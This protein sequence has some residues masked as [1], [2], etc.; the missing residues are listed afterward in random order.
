MCMVA[1]VTQA[2]ER[3]LGEQVEEIARRHGVIKR[4]RKFSGQSLL[5]TV[6]LTLLKNPRAKF[7]DFCVTAAQF[8]V[9]VSP[10][11]VEKRF[12]QS[13]A[14]FLKEVWE[15]AVVQLVA[16]DPAS[17]KLLGEFA[18]VWIGDSSTITLPDELEALFPG[19]GGT[20]ESGKA[21]LKLQLLWNLKTGELKPILVEPGRASDA[22]SP[23][24]HQPVEPGSLV[25]FDLGYFSVERFRELDQQGAKFISRLQHGTSVLNE[26]GERLELEKFLGQQ[27][28]SGTVDVRVLLG[29]RERLSCRL[30]AV[31]V[32]EE[33]ANR[34]R[35]AAWEKAQKHGRA[36]SAE[37][38]ALLVWTIFVTNCDAQ[39]L[40]WKA[41]VVLYRARWQIEL[42][43]KLWKSHNR[44]GHR[45]AGATAAEQ[46]AVLWATLIGVL[47][48]HWILLMATWRD[49]RRSLM[50][51]AKV[52]R[53]W[54]T[55]LITV[56]DA[57]RRLKETLCRLQ[58]CLCRVARV[59]CRRKN[60]SHHQL[61]ENPDLLNWAA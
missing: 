52:I 43:F 37:L 54:V 50:K 30:I 17:A 23:I 58:R 20:H 51:A 38:L 18:A 12:N 14:D 11:A 15:L 61:L 56:L 34:R 4:R 3:V 45:R 29:E 26:N 60:P 46:M 59:P 7:S 8:G 33:V 27:A 41:V 21:A 57:P 44:L 9:D 19:C 53:D 55:S 39:Q 13:L 16:A 32:P 25:V 49:K 24:A 28:V 1:T 47:L 10:T 6:V 22:K 5:R 48:Q 31:S 40:N 36:P 2:L 42:L 35:Q